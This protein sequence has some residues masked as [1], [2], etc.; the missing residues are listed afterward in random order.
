MLLNIYSPRV[1]IYRGVLMI[2]VDTF[3]FYFKKI[4]TDLA[5]F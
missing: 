5:Y 3:T 4:L 1:E 2:M